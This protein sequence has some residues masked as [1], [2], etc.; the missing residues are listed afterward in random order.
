MTTIAQAVKDLQD[1]KHQDEEIVIA[2]WSK[3]PEQDTDEQ[4]DALISREH[5]I[6][7]EYINEQLEILKEQ[8]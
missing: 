7:W 6:N 1:Y 5:K 4:W 8:L 3:D 2:W